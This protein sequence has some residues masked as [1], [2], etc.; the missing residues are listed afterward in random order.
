MGIIFF[1]RDNN[2]W[3]RSYRL[4]SLQCNTLLY[5]IKVLFEY[6]Y[7]YKFSYNSSFVI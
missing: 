3:E 2:M 1:G 5:K 7:L 4:V 6:K